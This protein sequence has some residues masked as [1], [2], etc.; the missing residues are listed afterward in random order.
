MAARAAALPAA[1]VSA[2]RFASAAAAQQSAAGSA[3]AAA[4]AD[5][6]ADVVDADEVDDSIELRDEDLILNW[7]DVKSHERGQRRPDSK[8][9][10][11]DYAH[12]ELHG[13]VHRVREPRPV[14]PAELTPEEQG[15]GPDFIPTLL[16]PVEWIRPTQPALPPP[17]PWHPSARRSGVLGTKLGM[18]QLWDHHGVRL[19]ITVIK[20][21][22][23]V[24]GQKQ[25]LS[26]KG[27][28]GLQVGQGKR[29]LKNVHKSF[30]VH[31]AKNGVWPPRRV[32]EF[33]CTPDGM[34]PVGWRF[35]VRHLVPGQFVDITGTSIG[36]GFQ[37]GM[38]KWGFGGLNASHG[39][40]VSHRS[41]GAT[42]SRQDP[43]RV[44]K[45]KK[46]PGRMGGT[47]VTKQNNKLFKIDVKNN[48]LFIVGHVPGNKGGFVTVRDAVKKPWNPNTPPPFPTYQTQKGDELVEEIV[49]APAESDPFAFGVA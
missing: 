33:P 30:L 12:S 48:L 27:L 46:M 41:I 18:M 31:C 4:A 8:R 39:V 19:P 2:R 6:D 36:K 1:S 45:N 14:I 34:L 43:G 28:L 15:S 49:C 5:A 16:R 3:S 40:S 29:K 10:P 47:R 9:D 22:C 7:R 37:G 26:P 20:V 23:Q 42:G 35:S 13:S 32:V 24:V 44:F 17:L 21:D 25:Q 11:I 38:K